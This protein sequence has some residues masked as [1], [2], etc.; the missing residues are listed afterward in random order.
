[1]EK[2]IRNYKL[3]FIEDD[4]NYNQYG[5]VNRKSTSPN[6]LES[7]DIINEYLIGEDNVDIIYLDFSK[8][9]NSESH[10]LLLVKMKNFG[11]SEK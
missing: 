1:M 6:I 8:A 2:L 11:T 4:I 9:F 10:Y 7:I 5:F 3:N